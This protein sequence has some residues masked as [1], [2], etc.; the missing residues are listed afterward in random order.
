MAT[1][2]QYLWLTEPLGELA[3]LTL[4]MV[5][6]YKFRPA[7]NSFYLQVSQDVDDAETKMDELW[8]CTV[9]YYCATSLVHFRT[10]VHELLKLE[11]TMS[12]MFWTN[13]WESCFRSQLWEDDCWLMKWAFETRLPE[14]GPLQVP[15]WIISFLN[16]SCVSFPMYPGQ[17][18]AS[19]QDTYTSSVSPCIRN[20]I[21]DIVRKNQS[22]YTQMVHVG[23]WGGVHVVDGYLNC[24][25]LAE[26]SIPSGHLT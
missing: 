2:F 3:T 25:L 10:W 20:G 26:C 24:C 14:S 5:T 7:S 8:V 18:L 17:G 12:V 9:L 21:C 22:R 11:C 15:D 13:Y 16:L 1:P 23:R 6:G 4:F 19:G